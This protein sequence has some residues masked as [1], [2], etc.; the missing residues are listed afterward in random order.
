MS[1]VFPDMFPVCVWH[2]IQWFDET[3][4]ILYLNVEYIDS[5]ILSS[6][7]D[8]KNPVLDCILAQNAMQSEVSV[9]LFLIRP[10]YT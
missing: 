4:C 6:K 2:D 3:V 10:T 1:T 5:S 7:I 9:E 8:I